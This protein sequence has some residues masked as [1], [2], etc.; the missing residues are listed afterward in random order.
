MSI[1]TFL[2][3]FQIQ[4]RVFYRKI[5][6]RCTIALFFWPYLTKYSS[7]QEVQCNSRKVQKS[8]FCIFTTSLPCFS[9]LGT[10]TLSV[11][12]I[13]CKVYWL[14]SPQSAIFLVLSQITSQSAPSHWVLYS[15]CQGPTSKEILFSQFILSRIFTSDTYLPSSSRTF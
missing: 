7:I 9:I 11:V 12:R 1:S 3:C 15:S 4:I 6:C 10:S 2:Q 5:S 8:I 14:V 13:L